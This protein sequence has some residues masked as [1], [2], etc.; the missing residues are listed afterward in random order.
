MEIIMPP[1]TPIAQKVAAATNDPSKGQGFIQLTVAEVERLERDA[2]N[3]WKTHQVA[4]IV[5]VCLVV[6]FVLGVLV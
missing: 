5:F 3:L 1:T 6:G 4:V 2:E